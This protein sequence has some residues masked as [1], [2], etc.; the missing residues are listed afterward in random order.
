MNS[1]PLRKRL[2]FLTPVLLL[3]VSQATAF[4][5][6]SAR[7]DGRPPITTT[8]SVESVAPMNS[9]AATNTSLR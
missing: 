2:R 8:N 6:E 3:V 5:A 9:N 4:A 7:A 1:N